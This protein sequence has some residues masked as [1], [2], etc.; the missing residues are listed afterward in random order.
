MYDYTIT[1][2]PTGQTVKVMAENDILAWSKALSI[3]KEALLREL[4][5]NFTTGLEETEAKKGINFKPM[6]ASD[7]IKVERSVRYKIDYQVSVTGASEDGVAL[8]K[9]SFSTPENPLAKLR[10]E[11]P[12]VPPSFNSET[13]NNWVEGL[14]RYCNVV[15]IRIK[16]DSNVKTFGTLDDTIK[17]VTISLE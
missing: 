2:L 4:M 9:G 3:Y 1:W 5:P 7:F 8:K 16:F 12:C 10:E 6:Q 11:Y 17:V 13:V 14:F 15:E